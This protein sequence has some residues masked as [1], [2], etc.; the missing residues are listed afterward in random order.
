[1]SCFKVQ[2]QPSFSITARTNNSSHNYLILGATHSAADPTPV[3]FYAH[4]T[5]I[6]FNA[7]HSMLCLT[8]VINSG[9]I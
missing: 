9:V 1:M 2:L 6:P 7:K 4:C 5:Y 3:F 8:K